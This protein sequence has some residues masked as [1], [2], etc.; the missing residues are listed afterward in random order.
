MSEPENFMARWSRRKRAAAQEVEAK[1]SSAASGAASEEVQPSEAQGD[2]SDVTVARRSASESVEPAF[3]VTKLPPLESITAA[4]DIRAFL[5]P[6]VPAELTRAALRRAWIADPKIRDFVGLAENAWDFNAPGSIA[7]FGPLEM[8]DDLR[9]EVARMV[10]RALADEDTDRPAPT[11]AESPAER[12]SVETSVE[13]AAATPKVPTQGSQ[14]HHGPQVERDAESSEGHDS[15]PAL[16]RNK[17]AIAAQNTP[18]NDDNDQVIAKR[19]HGSAL[20]K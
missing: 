20:P 11:S 12:P 17:V 8:T 7:G 4:S 14:S 19:P 5:A 13:S 2:E 9:R 15:G 18:E 10:G 16:Q 3:D 6:G 1:E